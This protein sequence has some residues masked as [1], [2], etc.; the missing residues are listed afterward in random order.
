MMSLSTTSMVPQD[1]SSQNKLMVTVWNVI[2]TTHT[3]RREI[4]FNFLA[5]PPLDMLGVWT[6]LKS[7]LESLGIQI[8]YIND[9]L[10]VVLVVDNTTL[11]NIRNDLRH[12][13]MKIQWNDYSR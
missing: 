5:I 12:S 4:R 6:E 8:P 9:K 2:H 10:Q 11:R 7:L 1:T 3:S 13:S